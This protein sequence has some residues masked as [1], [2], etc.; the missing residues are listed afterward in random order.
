MEMR[1]QELTGILATKPAVDVLKPILAQYQQNTEQYNQLVAS[2]T[3]CNGLFRKIDEAKREW[4]ADRLTGLNYSLQQ[5]ISCLN[6]A[7]RKT[8][9]I[10]ISPFT[11]TPK[12]DVR[13]KPSIV[14]AQEGYDV[15]RVSSLCGNQR[16]MINLVLTL[17]MAELSP[18]PFVLLDEPLTSSDEQ[19][20]QYVLENM[21]KLTTKS[22]IMT[23]HRYID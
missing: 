8:H 12:G 7:M 3:V 4:I 17:A 13:S 22:V 23:T 19:M 9:Q 15:K 20:T 2:L 1:R 6:K 14:I 16:K 5:K 10:V 18:F 21:K 11:Y